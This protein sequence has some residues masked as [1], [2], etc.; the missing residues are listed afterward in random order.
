M[1]RPQTIP[2]LFQSSFT[3]AEFQRLPIKAF[4]IAEPCIGTK[5]TACVKP[6]YP[7][8]MIVDSCNRMIIVAILRWCRIP[9]F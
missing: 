5:D 3:Y 8:F 2:S 1:Y 6:A 7:N 9:S 4:V